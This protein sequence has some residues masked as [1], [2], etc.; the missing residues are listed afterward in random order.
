MR[1]Q[2]SRQKNAASEEQRNRAAKLDQRDAD[3]RAERVSTVLSTPAGREFVWDELVRHD[4]YDRAGLIDSTVAQGLFLGR[5]EAG[6]ELLEEL[7]TQ[8]GELFL[9]MQAEAI[10]RMQRADDDDQAAQAV[11]TEEG[12][13]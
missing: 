10:A 12:G 3:R 7:M 6:I 9:L 13:A 2:R 11:T 1:R 4:V 8:H 5:R